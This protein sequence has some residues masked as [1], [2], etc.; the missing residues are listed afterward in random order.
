VKTLE[1][2]VTEARPYFEVI[3]QAISDSG[4]DMH[5]ELFRLKADADLEGNFEQGTF[6]LT[7]ASGK[8]YGR[9]DNDK[10]YWWIQHETATALSSAGLPL[11]YTVSPAAGDAGGGEL[12]LIT[13]NRLLNATD[14]KFGSTSATDFDVID[15][16]HI[17]VL[18]PAHVAGAANVTVINATGTSTPAIAFTYS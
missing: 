6:T 11:V 4:G 14:V 15:D 17:S 12:V 18:T 13:G 16:R 10:L 2:L 8:G 3:G 9:L 5:A 1:K 7:K